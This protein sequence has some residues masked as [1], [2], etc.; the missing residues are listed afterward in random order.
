M[1]S[2]RKRQALGKGLGA[3]IPAVKESSVDGE[4]ANVPLDEVFP[5]PGQPRRRF[6]EGALEELAASI[7]EQGVLQPLLVRRVP[8]GYE[9]VAGERRL[10]ASRMAGLEQVPI[11]VRGI[12]D[13]LRLE[14]ALIENI[15]REN[16]NPVEEAQA[17][18]ELQSINGYTQEEIARRVGKDRATVA[19]AMRL[20]S[21]PEFVRTALIEG[22]VSAGH[23]R[24]M[25]PLKEEKTIREMLGKILKRGL[26]VREVEL[27]VSRAVAGKGKDAGTKSSGKVSAETKDLE[28]RITRAL[29]AK[30]RIHE[31]ARG[32]KVE[33]RYATLDELNDIAEKLLRAKN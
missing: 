29:G 33:I 24:A 9:L 10:R 20:L 3:L 15:Q 22:A 28:K 27:A 12:E 31:G 1:K 16:L 30:T 32:G 13:E 6:E 21:L 11:M 14:L 5:N 23:A 17:Y 4:L 7:R 18:K 2:E 25:L 8:G 19:N 26:S